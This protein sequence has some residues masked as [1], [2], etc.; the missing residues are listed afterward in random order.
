MDNKPLSPW[1]YFGLEIL[2]SIPIVGFI[3]LICH[4]IGA[5]NINKRNFA[6]SFFC[7]LIVILIFIGIMFLIGSASGI[8]NAIQSALS[9]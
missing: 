5:V 1:A 4:A 3:F 2:Y 9:K 6:R 8:I 7:F